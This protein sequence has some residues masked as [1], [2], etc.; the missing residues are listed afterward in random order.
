VIRRFGGVVLAFGAV[1]VLSGCD[2]KTTGT[3]NVTDGSVTL[4]AIGRCD[5]GQRCT[6][7]WEYWRANAPRSSSIET[8]VQGPVNGPTGNVNLSTNVT[9]LVVCLGFSW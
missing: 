1:L 7:Y 8:P 3:T 5:S 9:N 4:T 2:A 6:W